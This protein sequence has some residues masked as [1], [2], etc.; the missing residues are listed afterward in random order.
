MCL[1]QE[2]DLVRLCIISMI[3]IQSLYKK[4]F[5]RHIH[6]IL[7]HATCCAV[8]FCVQQGI[9]FYNKLPSWTSLNSF[10]I[11]T[12]RLSIQPNYAIR[13]IINALPFIPLLNHWWARML[14]HDSLSLGFLISMSS[15]RS[16]RLGGMLLGKSTGELRMRRT[17][18]KIPLEKKGGRPTNSSKM[19][20][21]RDLARISQY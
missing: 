1:E 14:G 21:P 16:R 7:W 17:S 6:L 12:T 5:R 15:S 8:A 9:Y 11:K 20:Q 3:T 2:F 18:I 13:R 19:M 4:R 10:L